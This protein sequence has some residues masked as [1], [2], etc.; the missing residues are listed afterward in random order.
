MSSST[1]ELVTKA[2]KYAT[3]YM[4]QYDGSHNYQHVQRV[5]N[6][7]KIIEKSERHEHPDLV[8]DSTVVEL[9]SILHDIGDRKY[10][11]PGENGANQVE[12]LLI[13]FGADQAQA[14]LV[15]LIVNHVSYSLEIKDPTQVQRVLSAHP[16]LCIVQDADRL[17]AIGAIG[18][19][20]TFTYNAAKG[21]NDMQIPID[22]C[23]GRLLKVQNLMKTQK[24]KELAALR[25]ER[26]HEFLGW[27]KEEAGFRES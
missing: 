1:N 7:A 19:G 17:D 26:L 6:L 10:L 20:R 23:E 27:W 13:G 18:I 12:T 5:C 21:N 9:A 8:I 15:Q 4:N 3:E 14:Q 16:E 2:Q 11:R 24:G 25:T 22:Q